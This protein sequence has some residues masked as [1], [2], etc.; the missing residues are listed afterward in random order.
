MLI[1]LCSL[2]LT[3][4]SHCGWVHVVNV[5][6]CFLSLL[7]L[8]LLVCYAHDFP[9]IQ[10]SVHNCTCVYKYVYMYTVPYMYMSAC[11]QVSMS[12]PF[13]G[14]RLFSGSAGPVDKSSSLLLTHLQST[15]YHLS[16]LL[17]SILTPLTSSPLSLDDPVIS[18]LS[19]FYVT[20]SNCHAV[21]LCQYLIPIS[22][23]SICHSLIPILPFQHIR[24]LRLSYGVC[25]MVFDPLPPV[26]IL[27]VHH[28]YENV[29]FFSFSQWAM[30]ATS[31]TQPR[32]W[33]DCV[34]AWEPRPA[35]EEM[36]HPIHYNIVT[37]SRVVCLSL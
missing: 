9:C 33:P 17:A 32:H 22:S 37:H 16:Q 8:F 15:F 13:P 23:F 2:F 7:W 24:Y 18:E 25:E 14:N 19:G 26:T 35:R 12:L 27:T 31:Y 36:E 29:I 3:F 5:L 1:S 34:I 6:V 20:A 11:V 30:A 21:S 10:Y 4:L 28:R